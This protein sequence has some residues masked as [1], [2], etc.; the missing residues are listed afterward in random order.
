MN[1]PV[2]SAASS[3]GLFETLKQAAD[4]DKATETNTITTDDDDGSTKLNELDIL[5]G[6]ARLL[7]ISFSNNIGVQSLKEKIEAKL[8]E[9]SVSSTDA[10]DAEEA[11]ESPKEMTRQQMRTNMRNEQLRLV[12]IRVTNLNPAKKDVPGEIITVAN[13]TLGAIR[14]FVPFGEQTE[15]GYHVPYCIYEVLRT[16]EFQQIKTR[17]DSMGRSHIE[18]SMVREFAIEVL[19]QLT[20]AELAR[21]AAAQAAA[22]SID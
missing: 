18:S 8:A 19:P 13:R 6:R 4:A 17:K 21:L 10:T 11:S 2:T 15:N 22:G 12:R 20:E 5:K 7:G 16:R 1:T 3:S 14:K 9:T